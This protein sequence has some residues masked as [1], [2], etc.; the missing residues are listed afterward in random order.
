MTDEEILA[1]YIQGPEAMLAFIHSLVD[2]ITK[3]QKNSDEAMAR[4]KELEA[5][6]NKDS[7]NSSKPPSTDS[8]YNKPKP[9][10]LK[11]ETG[12]ASGGQKG[13]K[14][15]TLQQVAN[16]DHIEPCFPDVC[17]GCGKDLAD[18]SSCG[19]DKR[20]IIDAPLP[21]TQVWEYQSHHKVCP[22][23]HKE[24][25]AAFPEGVEQLI[26]YGNGI[27]SWAIYLKYYQL[28]PFKRLQEF[29]LHLLSVS[30]SEGSLNNW[31]KEC[32]SKLEPV[33]SFIEEQLLGSDVCHSDET[34]LR[35]QKNL[36][37]FHV[38]CTALFTLYAS[39]KKRGKEAHN[40]LNLLPKYTGILVHDDYSSYFGYK[41]LHGL[42][43]AHHLRTLIG[44][45]ETTGQTWTQRLASLL[46]CLY[47]E[48]EAAKLKKETS[49]DPKR[50]ERYVPCYEKL[51]SRGEKLHPKQPP[52]GKKGKT[53]QTPS[54]NLLIR[55]RENQ[56]SVL[57]FAYDF[58]VPF[59]N[60]Q[61]ERD[62]RMVKSR[63]K[64]SGCF[65][66]EAGIQQ[67]CRIRGYVSTLRKQGHPLLPA[68]QQTLQGNPFMPI[69][70][71]M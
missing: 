14:G 26:Q 8:T 15:T 34:G 43:N 19:F 47:R 41:Y 54:Y 68:I 39:H 6:I 38:F 50:L 46:R 1:I 58:R 59:D 69:P 24:N 20:Q 45:F 16:P 56:S 60:N 13:H 28:L 11:A 29:F 18:V 27:K 2:A 23:C 35:V 4:V 57:R 53:K 40:A 61:A 71:N 9:K 21:K 49:L 5:R 12:K 51:L 32:H 31:S 62:I 48:V 30:L 36:Y 66:S 25:V 33:E 55:L 52:D 17:Q 10:S 65:R 22:H 44:L 67:F 3:S 64:I 63:Q 70:Q 42:C 7:H 37:W